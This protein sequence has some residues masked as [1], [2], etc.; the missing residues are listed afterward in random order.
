MMWGA[1]E[2]MG[3]WM[4]FG[5]VFWVLFLGAMIY[6]IATLS[7]RDRQPAAQHVDS[8]LDIAKRRYAAGEISE[9]EFKRL[10]DHIGG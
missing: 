9:E 5:S 10:K 2:G 8:A 3:W 4:V 1:H 7:G 6:F